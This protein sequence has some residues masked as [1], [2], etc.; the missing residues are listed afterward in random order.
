MVRRRKV[1]ETV[2]ARIRARR[3]AGASYE[4]LASEFGL[5]EGSIANALKVAPS[6]P[7]K[8]GKGSPSPS[9]VSE[10]PTAEPTPAEPSIESLRAH[11]VDQVET[12]RADLKIAEDPATRAVINRLLVSAQALLARVMPPERTAPEVGVFVTAEQMRELAERVRKHF[13][14][15]VD[16]ST[17]GAGPVCSTCGRPAATPATG[18]GLLR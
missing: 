6:K 8:R 16:S 14:H 11:L 7:A 17:E 1:T 15:L 2:A 5:S 13:H 3:N 18:R 9:N 10:H 12:L 4:V